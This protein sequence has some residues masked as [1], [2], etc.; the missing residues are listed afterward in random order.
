MAEGCCVVLLYNFE[1]PL[2]LDVLVLEGRHVLRS[3]CSVNSRI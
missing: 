3:Q 1:R 2:T